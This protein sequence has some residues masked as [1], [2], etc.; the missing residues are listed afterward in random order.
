MKGF[1]RSKLV[2]AV[3][4]LAIVLV[5]SGAPKVTLA[6]AAGASAALPCGGG[7]SSQVQMLPPPTTSSTVSRSFLI[8]ISGPWV[9]MWMPA[10]QSF[11]R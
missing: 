11:T 8:T 10:R 3:V 2:L 4:A 7:V 9:T 6:H 5:G 1:F